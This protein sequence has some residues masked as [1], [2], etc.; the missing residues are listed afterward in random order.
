MGSTKKSTK[1]EISIDNNK[2]RIRLRWR[3]EGERYP[4]NSL[5]DYSSKIYFN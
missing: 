2:G 5:Y 4:L 1:G 3:F